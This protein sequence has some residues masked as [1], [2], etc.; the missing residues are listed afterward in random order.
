MLFNS[1]IPIGMHTL[2]PRTLLKLKNSAR[3]EEKPSKADKSLKL[4]EELTNEQIEIE[5]IPI[6]TITSLW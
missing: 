3:E 5:S 6:I 4:K 1:L 2:P